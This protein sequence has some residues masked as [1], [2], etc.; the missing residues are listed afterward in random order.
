MTKAVVW[1][2]NRNQQALRELVE[3]DADLALLQE[4]HPEGVD[5]DGSG[6]RVRTSGANAAARIRPKTRAPPDGDGITA[7]ARPR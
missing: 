7:A 1:N 2:I 3:T 6:R 4:V 5:G